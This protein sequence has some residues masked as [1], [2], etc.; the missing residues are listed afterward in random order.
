MATLEDKILGEKLH[1]YCSSSEGSDEEEDSPSTK[2]SQAADSETLPEPGKWDGI[3]KNTGPKGVIKDWQRYKQLENEKR[4][5]QELERIALAKKLT[6]SVKSALDE[7]REKAVLE[8]PEFAELLNDDF[9]LQYQK[10][11]MQEMLKQN[12]TDTKF[13]KLIYLNNG[14]EYLQVIDKENKSVTVI[15]HIYEDCFEACRTMNTCLQELAKLHEGIKFCC[16]I[17]S[18]AGMSREFKNKGVPAL[19]VY[20]GG[21]LI[22]NFVRITDSLGPSFYMEDV[23]DFLVEHGLLEDKSCLPLIIKNGTNDSESD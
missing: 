15:I 7:E 21:A 14:E 16:I 20:K 19:L 1:N 10:Q 8:D 9:L 13:G 5:E 4:T 12:E 22:N 23:Q 18:M 3:S 6:L 2:K 11:R 17:S